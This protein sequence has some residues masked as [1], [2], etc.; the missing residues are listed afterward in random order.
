MK[1]LFIC[2]LSF[3]LAFLCITT[4]P[5]NDV[6]AEDFEGNEDTYFEL[7]KSSDLD[8]DQIKTCKEFKNYISEKKKQLENQIK[9]NNAKI[10]SLELELKD[11]YEMLYE[12][13]DAIETQNSK[14]AVL[15]AQITLL[16]ESIQK[17]DTQIRERMYVTQS[18]L[19][20]NM[21]FDFLMGSSSIDDFFSR[22][23]SIDEL[24]AYDQDLIQKLRQEKLEVEQDRQLLKEEKERLDELKRQQESLISQISS[25][26]D[27]ITSETEHISEQTQQYQDEMKNISNSI[28]NALLENGGFIDGHVSTD[29]FSC[30]VE[31]GIV[32]A[33]N[34]RYPSGGL[35]LG[36][37]IGGRS[38]SNLYAPCDGVVIYMATGCAS[39][40]GYY[41]NTCN[42][43]CG[44]YL[45]MLSQMNGTTYA[46]KMYHM[47][48]ENYIGWSYGDFITVYRGQVLGFLGHSGSS[49]GPHL[50]L[51]IHN[52]G[53]VSYAEGANM[54]SRY[55]LSFGMGYGTSGYNN[56]CAVKSPPCRE[57][58][59]E[60][61]G[62]SL[63][64]EVGY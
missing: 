51:E 53:P 46:L 23:T 45:V 33:A 36:M 54:L 59:S 26:I 4:K 11:I 55:G 42:G 40:G 19:N 30:P 18:M 5:A 49:T 62:Y 15:D 57:N 27:A 1:K 35:H 48:N 6:H 31:W 29:G 3:C 50:H 41:G 2:F 63:Y 14:I 24:L 12:I 8:K 39:N 21:Y 58:A 60:L 7:C 44:N 32:T 13:N 43:G 61:L 47:I 17:R 22:M 37:D 16:E 25:Q 56:R 9:E 64:Q 20:S 38:G 10:D 28:E 52:L 34:W